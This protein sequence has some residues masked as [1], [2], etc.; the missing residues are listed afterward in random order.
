[1]YCLQ[2]CL[3]HERHFVTQQGEQQSIGGCRNYTPQLTVITQVGLTAGLMV[4]LEAL[5]KAKLES[6]LKQANLRLQFL[7]IPNGFSKCE[8]CKSKDPNQ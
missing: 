6:G 8:L 4:T 3:Q 7:W 5:M 1:M 2:T